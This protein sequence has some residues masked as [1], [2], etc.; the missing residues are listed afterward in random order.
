VRILSETSSAAN[1]RRIEAET[2][3]AAVATLRER[4]YAL[5]EIA[6][7][8]RTSPQESAS[9]VAVRELERRELARAARSADRDD[10][11]DAA[12]LAASAQAIGGVPVVGANVG[13][14]DA[15]A[16]LDV[17]DRVRGKLGR[18][19]VIVVASGAGERA[20]VVVSVAPSVVARGVRA[21]EIAKAAAAVLGGG[22]GGRDTLAQA[23]GERVEKIDEALAAAQAAVADVLG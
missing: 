19:G 9:A 7:V 22:G 17:A 3:P 14:I 16:L 1:V 6:G 12:A 11:A 13:P 5:E 2:G 20:H 21:G 23:G 8:L 18:D 15:K 4:S 10:A